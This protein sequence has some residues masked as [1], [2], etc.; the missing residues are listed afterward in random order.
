VLFYLNLNKGSYAVHCQHSPP[1]F[2]FYLPPGRPVWPAGCTCCEVYNQGLLSVTLPVVQVDHEPSVPTLEALLLS[3]LAFAAV[4]NLRA[5]MAGCTSL[6]HN[7]TLL[8]QSGA[9][10]VAVVLELLVRVLFYNRYATW[11]P[12]VAANA[13]CGHWQGTLHHTVFQISI[14][15]LLYKYE[16][17]CYGHKQFQGGRGGGSVCCKVYC[18]HIRCKAKMPGVAA[19]VFVVVQERSTSGS[20]KLCLLAVGLSI[21]GCFCSQVSSTSR[22]Q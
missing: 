21:G 18:M 3:C 1:C 17:A 5:M 16:V 10:V 11:V 9:A 2:G 7:H 15:G 13:H 12:C 14:L 4:H 19:V 22:L 8:L 20:G 6:R